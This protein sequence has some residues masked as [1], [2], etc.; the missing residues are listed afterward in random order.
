MS[1]LWKGKLLTVL[2][3]EM[4]VR[5]MDDKQKQKSIR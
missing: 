1:E 3:D 2:G 4:V 5:N